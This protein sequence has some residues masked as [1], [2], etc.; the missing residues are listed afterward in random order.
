MLATRPGLGSSHDWR[1][2]ALELE[3]T[4]KARA[5]SAS[6]AHVA[7]DAFRGLLSL[8]HYIPDF[9]FLGAPDKIPKERA[10]GILQALREI[11]LAADPPGVLDFLGALAKHDSAEV[12]RSAAT[13][14]AEELARFPD[15]A[16]PIGDVL[17]RFPPE[18]LV[19]LIK[20]RSG[21]VGD[22][23]SPVTA[24]RNHLPDH[25]ADAVRAAALTGQID[26]YLAAGL[27]RQLAD[28]PVLALRAAGKIAGHL[29]VEEKDA[30]P[31][32][33]LVHDLAVRARDDPGFRAA[34][35]EIIPALEEYL[36]LPRRNQVQGTRE[37]IGAALYLL[38]APSKHGDYRQL[39]FN[40][41]VEH[42]RRSPETAYRRLMAMAAARPEDTEAI[43][44]HLNR[45]GD[46]LRGDD[47]LK[48]RIKSAADDIAL[49]KC[50]FDRVG[51]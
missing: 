25:Y 47:P 5:G 3:K 37:A 13:F 39:A 6:Q 42:E 19:D 8:P 32:V 14:L 29:A 46:G 35:A 22:P 41:A 34:A 1:Q 51:Q 45:L 49:G 7:R 28:D 16:K 21:V 27:L 23:T 2:V 36:T 31:V 12:R 24:L 11:D 17:R 33:D 4:L 9:R 30:K 15:R 26:G 10:L 18:D 38:G 44:E 48:S 20:S 43:L 40:H 50:P